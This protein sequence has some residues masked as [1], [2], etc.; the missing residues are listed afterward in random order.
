[1]TLLKNQWFVYI[2]ECADNTLYTGITN[3][4]SR[5]IAQHN[6]GKAASYT[7][8]RLPVTLHYYEQA[9]SR[10][11]ALRREWKIK[12]MTREMKLDMIRKFDFTPI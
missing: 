6:R 7:R 10:G 12:H 1:M 8:G 2:V 5:R 11:D 3:N 9:N 4:L